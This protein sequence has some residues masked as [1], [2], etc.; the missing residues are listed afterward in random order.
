MTNETFAALELI[1]GLTLFPVVAGAKRPAVDGWPEW[2]NG[3]ESASNA[4][5]NCAGLLAI[6]VDVKEGRPGRESLE[7]LEKQFGVLP[8]TLTQRT[9]SGGLHLIFRA[10]DGVANSAG[11]IGPALDVRSDRGFVVA[12]GSRLPNGEYIIAVDAPIADAPQWLI[13]LAGPKVERGERGEDF[14]PDN[15][16]AFLRAMNRLQTCEVP[17]PGNRNNCAF[18]EV[19]KIRDYGVSAA[20]AE[21]LMLTVWN[22]RLPVPH[23]ETSLVETVHKAYLHARS[24]AGTEA[25]EAV[26]SP[27][28]ESSSPVLDEAAQAAAEGVAALRARFLGMQQGTGFF[29]FDSAS[30]DVTKAVMSVA[31]FEAMTSGTQGMLPGAQAMA[32][33]FAKLKLWEVYRGFDAIPPGQEV[34]DRVW[35]TWKGFSPPEVTD[36]VRANAALTAWLT[37]LE[38]NIANGNREY[39]NW[40]LNYFAHMVQR[41]GDKPLTALVLYGGKG[42]GKNAFID[43]LA[44][45]LGVH[46]KVFAHSRYLGSNFNGHLYG[47]LLAVFNEAFW[48]GDKGAD[49]TLKS[50]ITERK[51]SIER[52]GFEPM[53]TRNFMRL[54]IM[55]NDSWIVPASMDERRYAVFHV[56]DG[57]KQQNARFEE[58]RI[59]MDQCGGSSLLLDFLASI[60]VDSA[61]VNNPPITQAL[62]SQ[63]L[64]TLPL[65]HL[66]WFKMLVQ[67]HL[68]GQPMTNLVD[69]RSIPHSDFLNACRLEAKHS[70]QRYTNEPRLMGELQE[71]LPPGSELRL[72][73]V[74]F[75]GIVAAR[76]AFD[77]LVGA[78][79]EWPPLPS[80]KSTATG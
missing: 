12:A 41:P 17:L 16:P 56:G 44:V 6:D 52:K 18:A 54:V 1:H 21:R 78:P 71:I 31:T 10:P 62:I 64:R 42:T 58:L 45:P 2:K 37:H 68:S 24:S 65:A 30:D 67:G 59:G 38:R 53:E 66:T 57:W 43:R 36:P 14:I 55:G 25:P 70:G 27:V 29:L 13:N 48:S 73:T 22:P 75:P 23:E 40:I 39:A 32:A 61:L 72:T 74:E 79:Q 51:L 77:T 80:H 20:T 26:F 19:A 47:L 3:V 76:K 9:P 34:P 46:A 15:E 63:K 35:N 33:S 50:L 11:R 69:A 49:S 28:G 60:D 5:I 7:A 4:G 8:R